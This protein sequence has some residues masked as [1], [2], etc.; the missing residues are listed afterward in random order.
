MAAAHEQCCAGEG[1]GAVQRAAS[2]FEDTALKSE[3][4]LYVRV[5]CIK[6]S[7]TRIG[8]G[9]YAMRAQQNVPR[10]VSSDVAEK[11]T[12]RG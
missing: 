4:S 6:H 9:Q 5:A 10:L 7:I 11:Q 8:E 12:R 1:R 3:C 2:P